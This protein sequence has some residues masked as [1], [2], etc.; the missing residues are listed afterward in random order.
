MVKINQTLKC[1]ATGQETRDIGVRTSY[2]SLLNIYH[3]I[4]TDECRNNNGGCE[5]ICV[6]TIGG[7]RCSCHPGYELKSNNKDCEGT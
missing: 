2:L 4:E 6:D 5:Q 3:I 7:H 1:S